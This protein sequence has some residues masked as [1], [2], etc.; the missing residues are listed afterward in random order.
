MMITLKLE[1][2]VLHDNYY[3]VMSLK[4]LCFKTKK[5]IYKNFIANVYL[6]SYYFKYKYFFLLK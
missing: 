2:M 6:L 1:I 5:Y 3:R 4:N